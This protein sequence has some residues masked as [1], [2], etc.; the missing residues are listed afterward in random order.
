MDPAAEYEEM[1]RAA[2]LAEIHAQRS[3]YAAAGRRASGL[4]G[5]GVGVTIAK[6]FA[7]VKRIKPRVPERQAQ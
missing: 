7:R 4:D 5:D 3:I 1:R 6:A 2:N